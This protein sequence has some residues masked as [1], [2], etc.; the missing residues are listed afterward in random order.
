MIAN[1]NVKG[2][3]SMRQ[4][5]ELIS[6]TVIITGA[7]GLLG[8]EH[9]IAALS[10]GADLAIWDVSESGLNSMKAEL[11]EQFPNCRI[12]LQKLDITNEQ[13]VVD[14][15]DEM[16]SKEFHPYV[17]INN[18]A[19]NP[20]SNEIGYQNNRVESYDLGKWRNEIDVN[21][22]GTFIC[23]KILGS[24]FAKKRHGV[25]VNVASDLSVIAPDPRL[26]K[27]AHIDDHEQP[28]KPISYS[29]SKTAVVGLTRYLATYWADKGVRV[30]A[31]SP[32]GVFTD[33]NQDF[34]AKISEHVPLGRM[35]NRTEFRSAIQFLIS[36]DSSYMTGHNLVIDGGRSIW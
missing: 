23:S 27:I 11:E 25:I 16:L 34:V 32:G 21:L 12:L 10:L 29:V 30:N 18:A 24:L 1:E 2:I 15:L 8:Y 9:S 17:L 35:A 14:G 5:S 33:Q 31:I 6:K 19:I 7:G 28:V 20:T 3:A 4:S 36:E 22:T 26:Y 13:E